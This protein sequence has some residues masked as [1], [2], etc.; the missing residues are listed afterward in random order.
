MTAA[1]LAVLA[2]LHVA[3]GLGASIPFRT[4]DELADAVVGTSAGAAADGLFVVLGA[5]ATGAALAANVAPVTPGVRRSALRVMAGILGARGALGLLGKMSLVA[6]D[7]TSERFDR[8][9]PQLTRLSAWRS[10]SAQ[11]P[12]LGRSLEQ[13]SDRERTLRAGDAVSW[14]LTLQRG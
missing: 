2:A 4:R 1:L 10:L 8:L 13:S 12:P 6:P 3:W 9:D 7:S 14:V 11:W 5:L